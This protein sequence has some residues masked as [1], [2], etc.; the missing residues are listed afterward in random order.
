MSL[1]DYAKAN[2]GR[3]EKPKANGNEARA[4]PAKRG[5]RGVG[6]RGRGG[7]RVRNA[8]SNSEDQRQGRSDNVEWK[9]DLFD[10]GKKERRPQGV[11]RGSVA[12]GVTVQMIDVHFDI[13]ESDLKELFVDY[14]KNVRLE[15]LNER[16]TGNAIIVCDNI[17]TAK[18]LVN[19]FSKMTL[20]N[21][22]LKFKILPKP[23]GDDRDDRSVIRPKR[24]GPNE[25]RAESRQ[26]QYRESRGRGRGRGGRGRG[27]GDRLSAAVDGKRG[28]REEKHKSATDLDAEMAMFASKNATPQSLD[29]QLAAFRK[30][31]TEE[32][33][34]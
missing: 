22:E 11:T 12:K 34:K 31:A 29:D 20:D 5:G 15:Y 30:E 28:R 19:K 14:T 3:K 9:H 10:A 1:D 32:E 18:A 27:R 6:G 24:S 8:S 2:M 17:G 25:S 26:Q 7:R 23:G 16:P 13:T 21:H 33:A 4:A